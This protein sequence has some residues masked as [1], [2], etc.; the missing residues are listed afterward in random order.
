MFIIHHEYP[1]KEIDAGVVMV[2]K[3]VLATPAFA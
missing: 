2:G 1:I 3:I